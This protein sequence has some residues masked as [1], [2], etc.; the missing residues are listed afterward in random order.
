MEM[1]MAHMTHSAESCYLFNDKRRAELKGLASN[2]DEMAKKH[3]IEIIAAV[4]PPLEHEIYYLVEAP[5]HKA[6]ERYLKAIGL[7]AYNKIEIK[8]VESM[9]AALERL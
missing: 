6:V 2:K 5:S 1:F 8:Y 7:A 9:E 4:Y 3:Q